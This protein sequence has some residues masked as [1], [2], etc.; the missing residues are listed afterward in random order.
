M[1]ILLIINSIVHWNSHLVSRRVDLNSDFSTTVSH[2]PVNALSSTTI[3]I[4]IIHLV[5]KAFSNSFIQVTLHA[6]HSFF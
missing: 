6:P 5:I 1:A 3:A 4:I 2:L